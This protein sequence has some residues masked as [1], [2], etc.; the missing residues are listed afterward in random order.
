[1]LSFTRGLNLGDSVLGENYAVVLEFVSTY[2]EMSRESNKE[3]KSNHLGFGGS[4]T[5]GNSKLDPFNIE[6]G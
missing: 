3:A 6:I 2:Q 5:K 1:M 4:N